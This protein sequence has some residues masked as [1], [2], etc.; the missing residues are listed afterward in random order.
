MLNKLQSFIRQ[1]NMLAPGDTVICA[2]S[3]GADSMA[4]LWGMYLLKDKLGIRLE[5][6]HFNHHLRNEESDRDAAFVQEFCDRYEIP[7]YLGQAR[8]EKGEK[9]LEAAAREARYGFFATLS[10]KI[11]TA[12]TANDNAETLLMNLIRGTGL[13]GLG[14]ITPVTEKLIRPMLSV[15][16]QEVM[17]FL[18][19]YYIAYVQDSSNDTDAF[20]RNRLRHHVMPLLETENPQLAEN[21]SAMALRLRQDAACLEEMT[22][23]ADT[24]SVSKLR[25]LPP[26][27]RS[28]ILENFLKC[29]GVKEPGSRHIQGVNALVFSDKPS[30][31]ADLPEGICVARCYD[32]MLVQK[33]NQK[34]PAIL[35]PCPGSLHLS[36]LGM[37]VTCRPA[38]EIVN[39]ANVFTV[40]TDGPIYLESR[41]EGD[42]ITLPGGTKSLKKLFIDRK[43]PATQRL[44]IPVVRDGNGVLAVY[45][46]GADEK[47]K[48]KQKP[49]VQIIFEEIEE[50]AFE[51]D[52]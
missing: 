20:L 15:T 11:A 17:A 33:F 41:R 51:S 23:A 24:L 49:A 18:Q 13:K 5:A 26:A 47:R 9:G 25:E 42:S 8:V 43:I 12:H 35:L 50:G 37:K 16:R 46:I 38:E 10:G 48:A 2:V 14:G 4:L 40:E 45:G 44:R 39:T 27:I 22:R 28:R 36:L 30:A 3:G 19:E 34:L 32:S 52:A 29:N 6:A 31:R 7:L 1:Q 21:M